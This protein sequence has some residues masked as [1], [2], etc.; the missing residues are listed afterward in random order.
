[1]DLFLAFAVCFLFLLFLALCLGRALLPIYGA[2]IVVEAKEDATELEQK[3]YALLWLQGLGLLRCPICILDKGLSE[4]GLA[5]TQKLVARWQEITLWDD[6]A[7][8]K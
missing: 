6:W 7:I 2:W 3:L 8:P 5:L 1:M 4:E